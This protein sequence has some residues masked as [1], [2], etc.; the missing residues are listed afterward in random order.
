MMRRAIELLDG[1]SD[2]LLDTLVR[3]AMELALQSAS[4]L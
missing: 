1:L 4:G 3:A 2:A